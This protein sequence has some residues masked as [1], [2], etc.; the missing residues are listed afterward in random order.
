VPSHEQYLALCESGAAIFRKCSR[1]SYYSVV[2]SGSGRV[3]GTG[4]NGAPVGMQDC[5]SGGCPRSST[6]VAHGSE[7]SNCVAVHAEANALLH[8][9]RSARE[10][11][12]LYVNGPPCWDCSK[13]IAGSGIKTVVHTSD[14]A[15][16]D[17]PKCLSLLQSVGIHVISVA[18][19]DK[20]RDLGSKMGQRQEQPVDLAPSYSYRTVMADPY[21]QHWAL[22]YG[23]SVCGNDVRFNQEPNS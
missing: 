16:A 7:Y 18:G 2:L 19:L 14:S 5:T 6:D 4:Y 21:H 15:Y 9:D 22:G 8:S 17:W 12:T 3:L 10:G 20:P 13:L 1:R 23:P 11:G